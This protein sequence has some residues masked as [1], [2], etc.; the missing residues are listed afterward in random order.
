LLIVGQVQEGEEE[1]A[2]KFWSLNS[3]V[4]GSY[5]N[6]VSDINILFV[7]NG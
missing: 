2:D 5:D 7:V 1:K 4:A 3:Y 6:Q